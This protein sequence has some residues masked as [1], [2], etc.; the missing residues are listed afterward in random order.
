MRLSADAD[1]KLH[2]ADTPPSV[3]GPLGP[4]HIVLDEQRIVVSA[5]PNDGKLVGLPPLFNDDDRGHVLRKLLQGHKQVEYGTLHTLRYKPERRWVGRLVIDDQP[6]AVLRVY[7]KHEYKTAVHNAKAFVSCGPLRLAN[8]IGRSNR[9]RIVAVEWLHGRPLVDVMAAPDAYAAVT[10]T[11]AALAALHRQTPQDLVRRT[12]GNEVSEL[13]ALAD[14]VG[15]L[16]PDLAAQAHALAQQ[17]GSYLQRLPTVATAVHGDF[18]A[19]QVLFTD[20]GAAIL[21]FDRARVLILLP[22]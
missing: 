18:Y 11:G 19:D 10:A 2:N 5:L 14:G 4:G 21:D 20:H 6:R 15:A 12:R 16:C 1:V 8:R 13:H 3:G 17:L 22:T 9:R 7:A